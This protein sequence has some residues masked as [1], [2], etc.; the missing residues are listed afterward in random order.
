MAN[1]QLYVVSGDDYPEDDPVE[2]SFD[3]QRNGL[4]GAARPGFLLLATG[5]YTGDLAFLVERHD[6]APPLDPQ[7]EEVVEASFR[8]AAESVTLA[9]SGAPRHLPLALE[10]VDHRVRY[11]AIGFSD[12]I[13][14]PYDRSG[15]E[16]HLLQFWP[17]PPDS[18]R[19][20]R[21][22]SPEAAEWHKQFGGH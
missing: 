22:T 21:V 7:W 18:D 15:H 9:E 8:P 11:C 2:A 5:R 13:N 10:R 4:C 3:G 12:T 6:T 19:V 17:A 20:L 14:D 16:H 1:S